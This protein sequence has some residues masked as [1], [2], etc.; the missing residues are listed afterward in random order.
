MKAT[1]IDST[2]WAQCSP[3]LRDGLLV[4]DSIAFVELP[5]NDTLGGIRSTQQVYTKYRTLLFTSMH[6]GIHR[7]QSTPYGEIRQLVCPLTSRTD[8]TVEQIQNIQ[9]E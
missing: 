8:V 4:V 1:Q 7:F 6:A 2:F 5:V 9:I 3:L